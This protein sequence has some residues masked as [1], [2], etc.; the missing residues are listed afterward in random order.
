MSVVNSNTDFQFITEEYSC[1]AYVVEYVNKTNR[2]VN[3]LQRKIIET[4]DQHPE[5]DIVFDNNTYQC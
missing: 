2:G 3:N 4:M 5:F 1:A